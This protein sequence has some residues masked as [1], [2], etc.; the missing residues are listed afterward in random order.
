MEGFVESVTETVFYRRFDVLALR[1]LLIVG[2][3]VWIYSPAF[4]GGWIW[5]DT[6]YVTTHLHLN[7]QADLW[8]TWFAPG[9]QEDYYPIDSAVLLFQWHLWHNHTFGYH[10]T[11]VFLHVVSALLLWRLLAKIGIRHAWLGGLLFTVHPLMVESV[12]WMVELKNTLSLPPLILAMCFYVDY[13]ETKRDRGYFLA[14]GLFLVAM[15]CKASVMMLPTVIL[16]YIWWKRGRITWA[17]LKASLP[18]FAISLVLGLLTGR[19]QH[20]SPLPTTIALGW[21]SRFATAGWEMVFCLSKFFYPGTLLPVYPSG[22]VLSPT[23]LDLLPWL[24]LV[25]LLG[26][27]WFYRRSWGRHAL[28]GFG[29]FLLNLVPVFAF[30]LMNAATMIWTMDHVIYLP[31]IGLI[32]L[33]VAVW[34]Q[35]IERISTFPRLIV[36]VMTALLMAS[37]AWQSHSHAKIYQ[38]EETFWTYTLRYNPG[39]ALVHSS[40]GS[41]YLQQA[42]FAEAKKE[43]DEA[44]RINPD[45]ASAYNNLGLLQ[46]R[47]GPMSEKPDAAIEHFR[48][49]LQIEPND[50]E[51]HYNFANTLVQAGH[52]PEAMEQYEQALKLKP[53]FAEAH[54]SLGNA[55]VQSGRLAEAA[56]QYEEAIN[57]KP[58]Y[59]DA[60]ANLGNARLQLG[61]IPQ[62]IDQ[63]EQA[64]KITPSD[65]DVRNTLGL[66]LMQTGR[67]PEAETQFEAILRIDPQNA[68]AL[69]AL[70][71][72][73]GKRS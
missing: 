34:A 41:V 37:L 1:V 63:Y 72:I 27:L 11:N 60:H 8:K 21:P 49:S 57:L 69:S 48:S 22:L 4:Y 3:A 16:L 10:L 15:L 59:G 54:Y 32:G 51:V 7:H 19:L 26:V 39:S 44:L 33:C 25:I 40:L 18:F 71:K 42:R 70:A 31:A 9:T 17:D 29:F 14:L 61:Q 52:L 28:L 24:G 55:L 6:V 38:N 30:A 56:I 64:L 45:D 12:A 65:V 20:Q 2:A 66:V 62:A 68:T 58:D 53:D 13:E 35:L 46:Q 43:F 36:L 5:D 50:P 73:K 47:A 23:P 67:L